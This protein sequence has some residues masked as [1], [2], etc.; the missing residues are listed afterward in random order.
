MKRTVIIFLALLMCFMFASCVTSPSK[1]LDGIMTSLKNGEQEVVAMYSEGNEED[2]LKKIYSQMSWNIGDSQSKDGEATV[3][4]DITTTDMEEVFT[5]FMMQALSDTLKGDAPSDED[6]T[7]ILTDIL[8][9]EEAVK[10]YN[11]SVNMHKEDGKWV[12][13]DEN[14]G[15]FNAITGG[16]VNLAKDFK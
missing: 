3:E 12:I 1:T 16:Y 14:E 4:I 10:T 7:K 13:A 11:V 15:F 8:E 9:N 5:A 2:V 6:M